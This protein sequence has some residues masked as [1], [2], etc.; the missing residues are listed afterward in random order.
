M[1]KKK[2]SFIPS[3][4]TVH[5]QLQRHIKLT[6]S[7]TEIKGLNNLIK[8]CRLKPYNFLFNK[9][10]NHMD[11]ILHR[12]WVDEFGNYLI[13]DKKKIKI[14]YNDLWLHDKLVCSDLYYGLSLNK[15]IKISKCIHIFYGKD[16]DLYQDC[17]L[18]TFVGLDNFYRS[19]LFLYDEWQ[20]VSSLLLGIP[21]LLYLSANPKK[22]KAGQI[23]IKKNDPIPCLSSSEWLFSLPLSQKAVSQLDKECP[24]LLPF[25]IGD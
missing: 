8:N 20:I 7:Y 12:E 15:I 6:E 18:I 17:A 24:S 22:L 10:Y 25:L 13:I 1:R 19:Y 5:Y 23:S 3:L 16:E 14:I 9:K 4:E 21:S 2:T 11:V